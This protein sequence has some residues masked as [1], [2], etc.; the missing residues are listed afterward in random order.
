MHI[1]V[2]TPKIIERLTRS[3]KPRT[4]LVTIY[5]YQEKMTAEKKAE[6]KN[7]AGD[8][9]GRRKQWPIAKKPEL[10]MTDGKNVPRNKR[11]LSHCFFVC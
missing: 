11:P 1:S 9:K 8:K 5:R 7:I 4:N 6:G 3:V 10:K 2:Y